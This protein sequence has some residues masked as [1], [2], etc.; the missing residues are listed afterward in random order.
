MSFRP[1][2]WSETDPTKLLLN[3]VQGQVRRAMVAKALENPDEELPPGDYLAPR[4]T[5]EQRQGMANLHPS[6][7]GG[8]YLPDM[9]DGE[10]EIARVVLDS[11]MCD[12][13]SVRA[14]RLPSGRIGYRVVD[15]YQDDPESAAEFPFVLPFE[16]SDQPLTLAE[17]V[18]FMSSTRKSGEEYQRGLLERHWESHYHPGW[19]EAEEA[20]AFAVAESD[21]YPQLGDYYERLG[22]RKCREWIREE[23]DNYEGKRRP[24]GGHFGM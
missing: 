6:L 18:E 22:A 3:S 14:R 21:F 10:V 9:E 4:L 8:E 12:V 7:M 13:T 15:E 11:V 19:M 5:A 17:L 2:Y 23:R 20:V 16:E 1:S 24:A